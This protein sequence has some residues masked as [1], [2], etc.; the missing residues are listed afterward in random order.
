MY[1][2]KYE[3]KGENSGLYA[4]C[5]YKNVIFISLPLS[6]KSLITVTYEVAQNTRSETDMTIRKPKYLG[7]KHYVQTHDRVVNDGS[8][9]NTMMLFVSFIN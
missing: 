8:P 6:K 1:T 2:H 7:R 4:F 5:F 3:R 9:Y